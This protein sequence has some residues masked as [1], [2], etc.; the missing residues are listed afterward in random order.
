M[1]TKEKVHI[2][3]P[4]FENISFSSKQ[5][6]KQY[7]KCIRKFFKTLFGDEETTIQKVKSIKW[8]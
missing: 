1:K 8:K 2:V 5:T 3:I 4:E 7:Y 6:K